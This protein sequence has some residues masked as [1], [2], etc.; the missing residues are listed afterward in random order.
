V[1]DVR[2]PRS[3]SLAARSAVAAAHLVAAAG[4]HGC[5]VLA[6]GDGN[7]GVIV[8]RCGDEGESGECG[9]EARC[10]RATCHAISASPL[11]VILAISPSLLTSGAQTTFVSVVGERIDGATGSFV[12]DDTSLSLPLFVALSDD[13]ELYDIGLPPPTTATI[14][15]SVPADQGGDCKPISVRSCRNACA[16]DH[17]IAVKATLTPTNQAAGAVAGTF[18]DYARDPLGAVPPL[19][20]VVSTQ[21]PP[22]TYDIYLEQIGDPDCPLP[23]L[24]T[25][26]KPLTSDSL[27]VLKVPLSPPTTLSGTIT[28][29][30][31]FD[32]LKYYSVELLDQSTGLRLSTV[33]SV[34]ATGNG[35]WNFGVRGEGDT[36]YPIEYYLPLGSDSAKPPSPYL[37]LRPIGHPAPAFAWELATVTAFDPLHADL[38]LGDFVP[39]P[40]Q[41]EGKLDLEGSLKGVEAKVWLQ[42]LLKTQLSSLSGTPPGVPSFFSSGVRPSALGGELDSVQLLPGEYELVAIAKGDPTLAI[43]RGQTKVAMGGGGVLDATF[44]PKPVLDVHVL[45]TTSD[46]PVVDVPVS[47]SASRPFESVLERVFGRLPLL[48]RPGAGLTDAAGHVVVPLDEGMYD[49]SVRFPPSSGFP[50]LVKA[51]LQVPLA[52]DGE[53]RGSPPVEVQGVVYDRPLSDTRRKPLTRGTIRAYALLPSTP[54]TP[55]RPLPSSFVPIA[56][57]PI[58]GS[59]A[60]KLLLPSRL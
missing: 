40:I 44:H 14:S 36:L 24:L 60:Y 8:N 54:G 9:P 49:L 59:G 7:T 10:L 43:H 29:D 50:W 23:P 38:D 57:A 35:T 47:A 18:S 56:E 48:P 33:G 41:T 58:D 51:R 1:A 20:L 30:P 52:S 31:A 2:A 5:T 26:N 17:T 28:A 39:R 32:D 22:D 53:L 45:S 37:V 34:V 11:P 25:L 13:G 15:V 27:N 46:L 3:A 4:A 19:G 21:V 6:R 12:S 42:S 16:G 55:G